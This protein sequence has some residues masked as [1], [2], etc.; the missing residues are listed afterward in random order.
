[1]KDVF[2]LSD[3]IVHDNSIVFESRVKDTFYVHLKD[4]INCKVSKESHGLYT[5]EEDVV[6]C[7]AFRMDTHVEVYTPRKV[8]GENLVRKV[9]HNPNNYGYEDLQLFLRQNIAENNPV[10]F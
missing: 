9:Y 2:C 6:D 4:R 5:L 3:L 1:M 8:C 10:L 7:R